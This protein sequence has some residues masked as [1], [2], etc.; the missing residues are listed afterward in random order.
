MKNNSS[1]QVYSGNKIFHWPRLL[2]EKQSRQLYIRQE[3]ETACVFHI[4]QIGAYDEG[5]Q[6][7]RFSVMIS[8]NRLKA[9]STLRL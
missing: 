6:T 9:D 8:A 3:A 4:E 5:V 1:L 2:S 7:A